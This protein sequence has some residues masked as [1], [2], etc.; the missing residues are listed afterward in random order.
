MTWAFYRS[1][2]PA[3]TLLCN[4]TVLSRFAREAFETKP[5]Y[6][7]CYDALF[8]EIVME[9]EEEGE[10]QEDEEEQE[11]EEQEEEDQEEDEK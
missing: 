10:E 11:K 5:Q 4:A 8:G 3:Q 2:S 1:G 7:Q 6:F 9:P